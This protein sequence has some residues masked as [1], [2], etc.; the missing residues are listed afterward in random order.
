MRIHYREGRRS[1][2]TD[3]APVSDGWGRYIT[4]SGEVLFDLE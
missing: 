4:T 2:R 3:A 1:S